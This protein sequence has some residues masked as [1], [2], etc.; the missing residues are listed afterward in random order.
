[1]RLEKPGRDP[2]VIE[3]D[4]FLD[5][6]CLLLW[7]LAANQFSLIKYFLGDSMIQFWRLAQ[8]KTLAWA[9]FQADPSGPRK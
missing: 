8:L 1:M 3:H 9:C 6:G 5:G 7:C 4:S 2:T